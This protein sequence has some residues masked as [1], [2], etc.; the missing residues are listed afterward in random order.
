MIRRAVLATMLCVVRGA[1][2]IIVCVGIVA[3]VVLGI[4]P[5]TGL[6]RPATVLSG[7]MGPQ[8]PTGSIVFDFPKP[9]SQVKVGDVITY[10]V[11]VDDHH[12]VTHRVVEIVSGGDQPIVRTQGDA[13]QA[14]D[15]WFARLTDGPVW[16]V[17][18]S[19]PH[20]GAVLLWL[21]H[22]LGRALTLIVTPVFLAAFAIAKIWR[23]V[24]IGLDSPPGAPVTAGHEISF[25]SS[26][27]LPSMANALSNPDHPPPHRPR[28]GDDSWD[29]PWDPPRVTSAA[30]GS[31]SRDASEVRLDLD[32]L[33]DP[34]PDFV[35]ELSPAAPRRGRA[36]HLARHR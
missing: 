35:I 22:P 30:T 26:L 32:T 14:P 4:G 8:I 24:R 20:L 28:F 15:V 5:R 11:P 17:R 7:S 2:R 31:P 16:E 36:A 27:D 3:V 29:T 9:R 12:L 19:I 23:P 25:D 1:A 21:R 18:A 34:F 10:Q 6:Y 33:L 13:N